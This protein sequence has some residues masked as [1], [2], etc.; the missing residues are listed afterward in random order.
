[1]SDNTKLCIAALI[2]CTLIFTFAQSL[3]YDSIR[4]KGYIEINS[5][6]ISC[7][8]EDLKNKPSVED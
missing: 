4:S 6:R 2:I 7:I 8:V 3:M 1:M 5:Q